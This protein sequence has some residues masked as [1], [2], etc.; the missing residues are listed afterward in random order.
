MKTQIANVTKSTSTNRLARI[1]SIATLFLMLC[2]ASGAWAQTPVIVTNP[3]SN[4]VLHTGIHFPNW[5]SYTSGRTATLGAPRGQSLIIENVNISSNSGGPWFVSLN[6]FTPAGNLRSTTSFLLTPTQFP[7]GVPYGVTSSYARMFIAQL[8][9][10]QFVFSN[11]NVI[12]SPI[13]PAG[14]TVSWF[15]YTEPYFDGQFDDF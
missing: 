11:G 10:C 9:Q 15:G 5:G 4:P 12:D 2:V 3:L 13:V 1:A 6:C 8:N 7:S 14:V